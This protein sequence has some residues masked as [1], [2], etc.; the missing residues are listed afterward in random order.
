VGLFLLSKGLNMSSDNFTVDDCCITGETRL[1]FSFEPSNETLKWN[2]NTGLEF[3]KQFSQFPLQRYFVNGVP[4]IREFQDGKIGSILPEYKAVREVWGST[5]DETYSLIVGEYNLSYCN[6]RNGDNRPDYAA[7]ADKLFD[8]LPHYRNFWKPKKIK[9]V[10]LMI[11]NLISLPVGADVDDYFYVGVKI[12]KVLGKVGNFDCLIDIP[13]T[14]VDDISYRIMF[15][16]SPQHTSEE[17]L[18]Q[19]RWFFTRK[20]PPDTNLHDL[21][22]VSDY[23]YLTYRNTFHTCC[24]LGC[25]EQINTDSDLLKGFE[26]GEIESINGNERVLRWS[27]DFSESI[28]IANCPPEFADYKVGDWFTAESYRNKKFELV[29]LYNIK[30]CNNCRRE[31][32]LTDLEIQHLLEIMSMSEKK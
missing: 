28:D 32:P 14:Q 7:T 20:E 2:E 18:Y 11:E 26:C 27:E 1:S 6:L 12:P 9:S 21:R 17:S 25:K 13:V 8:Y 5:G 23:L 10:T 29:K 31:G 16:Q 19:I 4:T 15:R 3:I 22:F 24:K 30:P